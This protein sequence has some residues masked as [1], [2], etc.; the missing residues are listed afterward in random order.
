[1]VGYLSRSLRLL[2]KSTEHGLMAFVAVIGLPSLLFSST[3]RLSFDHI[4][5]EVIGAIVLAKLTLIVFGAVM[6]PKLL[7]PSKIAI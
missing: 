6:E 5:W 4:Q 1:M 2:S 7:I 3:C